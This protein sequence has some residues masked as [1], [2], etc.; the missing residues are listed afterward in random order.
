MAVSAE[1]G[2]WASPGA[3]VLGVERRL[4]QRMLRYLHNPPIRVV[5]WNGE[6]IA[7]PGNPDNPDAPPVA[8][9]VLRDRAAFYRLLSNPDR[10]FGELYSAGRLVIEGDLLACIEA[11]YRSMT[12]GGSFRDHVPGR[13]HRVGANTLGRSRA[14]IHRHYDIG[15]DFYRLWL[16]EAMVYTCAYFAEP[17]MT[18]GAAQQAKMEHV[19][20]KLRLRP[21]QSVIEAGCGWGALAIHMA[22]HH[23]VHVRAF[24][25]SHE[26]LVFARARAHDL[27]LDDRVEFIED[28]YRNIAGRCDAFVSVGMLEHVGPS[29]YQTLGRVV[30]G[31]LSETGLALIHSIG[32]NRPMRMN[33]WI[34]SCI[35]P[36]GYTP[37]LS[38]MTQI[39]EPAGFSVLDVE[40]LRLHYALT[41]RN[42]LDRYEQSADRVRWMFD[43]RFV[44]MWR[45]YLAGSLAAF[46]TGW[47]QLFQV[48]F[49][50]WSNNEIPMTRADLY[51]PT[52]RP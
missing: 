26:Q 6:S 5:M 9:V 45:L 15:N 47:M 52:P 1:A 23:G 50:R 49:T 43:D 19:C 14:H 24:N 16:D 40:N 34:A 27:G 30:D 28:D 29:D 3:G 32:R 10:E 41:L 31:C 33:P 44:R 46:T 39:F 22:Q 4:A 48:V 2:V 11:V 13:L 37:A 21:G 17:D 25:I 35:F 7:P 8:R 38:E 20:R 51:R 18:L 42:W 36:G 12:A